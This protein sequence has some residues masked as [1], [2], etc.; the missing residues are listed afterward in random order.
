MSR[1]R[2]DRIPALLLA[3][4]VALGACAQTGDPGVEVQS[5]QAS[6]VF[7]VEIPE[8]DGPA[9]SPVQTVTND[10]QQGGDILD[11]GG[12]TLP[13][14]RNRIPDRFQGLPFRVPPPPQVDCPKA[15]IGASVAE[16]ANEEV[17]GEPREGLYKWKRDITLTLTIQGTDVVQKTTG[18]ESRVIRGVEVVGASTD[19][20]ADE[21]GKQFTFE[22]VR[23]DGTGSVVVDRYRVN[24][25]PIER[26]ANVNQDP[27]GL[28][29]TAEATAQGGGV[30]L[31]IP[32]DVQN[33]IPPVNRVRV[34]EPNRGLT[35]NERTTFD[36]N[37]QA[38]GTFNPSPPSLLL[39]FPVQAGDQWQSTSVSA[40]NGQTLRV[41]GVVN[42][43]KAVDA[44]G[45][46]ID[47]WLAELDVVDASSS[48]IVQRREE[49]VVS[50]QFGGMII[51]QTIV[52]EGTDEAGNNVKFEAV[53]TIAQVDP[54]PIPEGG[55]Q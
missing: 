21:P 38:Q 50:T 26:G 9:D 41:E 19:P 30:P 49:L 23:P 32:D 17:T 2:S 27:R 34:G 22:M 14:F 4:G 42:E 31:D 40:G 18:F 8:E 54:D 37:G 36:G 7:G 28:S 16:Q 51:G 53:Y 29:D 3:S 46:L 39:P 10:F 15:G 5:L 43:R 55:L 35:L 1:R 24:T 12:F 48:N 52:E 25:D 33:E 13:P 6:V 47:G 11:D 45:T 20:T 44:C